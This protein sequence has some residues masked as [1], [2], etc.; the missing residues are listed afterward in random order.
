MAWIES[1]QEL[2][3]HP[4]LLRLARS[5]EVSPVTAVGHLHYLWWWALDFAQDGNLSGL[6]AEEVADAAMW[7]G[8]A[9]VF[10]DALIEARFIDED[11]TI[12]DWHDYA[13]KLI[14]RRKANAERKRASRQQDVPGTDAGR[15]QDVSSHSTVPNRTVPNSTEQNPSSNEDDSSSKVGV[16]HQYPDWFIPLT[17]LVGFKKTAHSKAIQTITDGCSESK[18]EIT[19]VVQGF[20]DYYQ[21]GG[22][23]QHGWLDPVAALTKTLPIQ[24]SK[25]KK[26]VNNGYTPRP[27]EPKPT[28]PALRGL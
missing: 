14:D 25:S 7:T 28:D 4:K 22:R 6:L 2:G 27:T 10:V 1:H 12:H 3:R 20:A 17:T 13:G 24:I 8:D 16:V 26:V 23:A 5:L 15:T 19:K 21:N 9:S 11:H 18:V